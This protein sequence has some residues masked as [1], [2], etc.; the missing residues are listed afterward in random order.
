MDFMICKESGIIQLEKLLPLELVYQTFHS[1]A[2]KGIWKEHHQSFAKFINKVKPNKV[3]EIGGSNGYLANYY[4]DNIEDIKWEIIEPTPN[5]NKRKN[6]TV[7]KKFFEDHNIQ[8][9]DFTIVHSHT[10][11]HSYDIYQFLKKI[12]E[13][14]QIGEYH[15]FSVPNLLEYIKRCYTNNLNFEH[16]FLIDEDIIAYFMEVFGF[17][18]IER[19]YFNEHSIFYLTKKNSS[20]RHNVSIK[21]N[22]IR[23]KQLFMNFVDTIKIEVNRLNDIINNTSNDHI[24]LF[25]AHI[26]SQFLINFGLKSSK[27]K[28]ILDNSEIKQNKRLYGTNLFVEKPDILV[29]F[30]NPLVIIKAGQY[31]QEIESQI[32]NINPNSIIIN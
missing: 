14:I 21:N 31:Q 12:T 27:L 20:I 8:S 5:I 22:Y 29:D 7:H 15:I 23:N 32:Q 24:F 3:M 17:E 26:F 13:N 28:K 6:I 9:N 18:I 11:E 1:E 4:L 16:T 2:V 25:G 10:L 19:Q 30:K